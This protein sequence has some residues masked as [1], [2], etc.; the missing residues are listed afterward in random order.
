MSDSAVDGPIWIRFDYDMLDFAFTGP[1]RNPRT[2]DKLNP[3]IHYSQSEPLLGEFPYTDRYRYL[4]QLLP[5]SWLPETDYPE[6]KK[7]FYSNSYQKSILLP[8]DTRRIPYPNR[9]QNRIPKLTVIKLSIT[10]KG[11]TRTRK[12]S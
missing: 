2:K 5:S 6:P 8:T 7:Y 9:Y 3:L 10:W 11:L 4:T 12:Y 1:I